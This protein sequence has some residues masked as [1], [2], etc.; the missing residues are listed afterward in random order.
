MG[1]R[2]TESERQTIWDMRELGYRSSASPG[3]WA[4]RT[5]RFG[6]SL[7]PGRSVR[8]SRERCELRLCS[9]GRGDLS[10]SGGG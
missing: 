7:E 6:C 10:G 5:C 3:I 9:R 8:P 2:F 4:G 1:R